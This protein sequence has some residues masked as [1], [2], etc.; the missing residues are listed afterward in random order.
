MS[1]HADHTHH[2]PMASPQHS[3]VAR[4]FSRRTRVGLIAAA[5]LSFV[6]GG[7]IPLAA[8]AVAP[9]LP[10][11]SVVVMPARAEVQAAAGLPLSPVG[12]PGRAGA[13]SLAASAADLA[14]FGPL[15]AT[16]QR[17][18]ALFNLENPLRLPFTA[19]EQA[20]AAWIVDALASLGFA[21]DDIIVQEFGIDLVDPLQL[22]TLEL[23]GAAGAPDAL[24]VSQNVFVRVAG[25]DP[26]SGIIVLGAGYDT[27]NPPGVVV[28]PALGANVSLLLETAQ[29][30]QNAGLPQTVYVAFFG[31]DVV[32]RPGARH[33]FN[34]LPAAE[35]AN[36]DLVVNVDAIGAANTLF[37]T[38]EVCAGDEVC[39]EQSAAFAS[40][41]N[42]IATDADTELILFKEEDFDFGDFSECPCCVFNTPDA[43]VGVP[44]VNL[45]A[46]DFDGANAVSPSSSVEVLRA[47]T[48]DALSDYQQ[49]LQALL[50]ADRAFN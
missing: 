40:V 37:F 26:N 49:F 16:G 46:F 15:G 34:T 3:R 8:N 33:F 13:D 36:I 5:T 29:R 21:D 24:A 41:V 11:S 27:F 4:R 12:V 39:P 17:F 30:V 14:K 32:G 6:V 1:A 25:S 47:Q 35:Q 48:N 9:V 10:V 42:R 23:I 2:H 31:A 38:A 50:R 28:D 19:G 43:V 45:F 22:V 18:D 7:G 44:V 20:A